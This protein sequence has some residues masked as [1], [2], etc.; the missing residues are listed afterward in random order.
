MTD[1]HVLPAGDQPHPDARAA[2]A[3]ALHQPVVLE[4]HQRHSHRRPPEPE[5]CAELLLE[6]A[7]ARQQVAV[8]DRRAQIFVTIGAD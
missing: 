3:L 1:D 5:S 7:F 4:A 6:Q 8:N 2:V